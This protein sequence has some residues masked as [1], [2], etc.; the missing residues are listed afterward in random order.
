MLND[1]GTPAHWPFIQIARACLGSIEPSGRPPIP[2]Y[3]ITPQVIDEVAQ[4]GPELRPAHGHEPRRS[5]VDPETA[6]FH[7]L[8]AM[9][10]AKSIASRRHDRRPIR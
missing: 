3:E 7:L 10:N 1:G 4:I 5:H 2:E 6:R 8:D 9:A